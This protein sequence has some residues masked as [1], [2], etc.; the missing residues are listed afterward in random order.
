MPAL[1]IT[2]PKKKNY[3]VALPH[4]SWSSVIGLQ[5]FALAIWLALRPRARDVMTLSNSHDVAE[6]SP[7]SVQSSPS[8][9][10][11]GE[12]V[13]RTLPKRR[14]V[15]P[16]SRRI[17]VLRLKNYVSITPA[18]RRYVFCLVSLLFCLVGNCWVQPRLSQRC[19]SSSL[20]LPASSFAIQ[21]ILPVKTEN[22]TL[23][24]QRQ[25]RL[26]SSQC[27]GTHAEMVYG[28]SK[29]QELLLIRCQNTKTLFWRVI[30][31]LLDLA[32]R[33]S[34]LACSLARR[35]QT[36]TAACRCAAIVLTNSATFC[37]GFID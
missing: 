14:Q 1:F 6:S 12:L 31:F 15:T 3:N 5:F 36:V 28:L 9:N 4:F 2:L 24:R 30:F 7:I 19:V 11:Q 22:P 33:V 21:L 34:G 29:R 26:Y 25:S 37:K 8:R 20:N 32:A 16:S 23:L 35:K 10:V 17:Y 27:V 18:L 13:R